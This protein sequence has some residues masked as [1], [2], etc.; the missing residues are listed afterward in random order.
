LVKKDFPFF[1]QMVLDAA[2]RFHADPKRVFILGYSTGANFGADLWSAFGN[3]L[4]G[5]VF[6]SG[7]RFSPKWPARPVFLSF[8]NQEPEAHRLEAMG[9]SLAKDYS[10]RLIQY[11]IDARPDGHTYPQYR[12]HDFVEFLKSC[13]AIR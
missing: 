5:F 10:Q 4:A 2:N 8:G 6:V 9:K 13:P 1:R 3:Q 12:D 11:R 7:G